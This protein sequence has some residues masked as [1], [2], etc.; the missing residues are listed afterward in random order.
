M[1]V[2]TSHINGDDWGMVQM[3]L[4][5]PTLNGIMAALPM[6]NGDSP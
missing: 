1:E 5:F 6:K 4:F 3:T 2:Y